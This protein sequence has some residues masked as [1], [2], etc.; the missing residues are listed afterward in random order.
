MI[1][2]KRLFLLQIEGEV[3]LT[4]GGA[5]SLWMLV[6]VLCQREFIHAACKIHL[7]NKYVAFG[8]HH[9]APNLKIYWK[10]CIPSNKIFVPPSSPFISNHTSWPLYYTM[11]KLTVF[12]Y[13]HFQQIFLK[14]SWLARWCCFLSWWQKVFLF[15]WENKWIDF[16]SSFHFQSHNHGL[17]CLSQ[18]RGDIFVEVPH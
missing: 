1:C 10:G 5:T 18:T 14:I 2:W 17:W 7:K 16:L 15:T 3:K 6:N 11:T 4:F 9:I 12:Q 13:K 8:I